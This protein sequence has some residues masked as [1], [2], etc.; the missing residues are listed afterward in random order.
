MKPLILAYNLPDAKLAKLQT[1]AMIVGA[2]VRPVQP[3]EY[4]SPVGQLAG[5]SVEA[6]DASSEKAAFPDEMIVLCGFSDA[7]LDRLLVSLR[8]KKVP[9]IA[10]KAVLTQSNAAWTSYELHR[11]L[12]REREA[13]AAGKTAHGNQ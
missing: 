12:S 2:R 10:L 11:E 4:A 6:A 9:P 3:E 1:L 13:I 8:R 7:M 5:L